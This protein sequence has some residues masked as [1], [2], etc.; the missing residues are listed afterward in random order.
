M[1]TA[2][3]GLLLSLLLSCRGEQELHSDCLEN[4]GACPAR[5]A[6]TDCII[7]SNE[8]H[9]NAYCTHHDRDP[10]LAVNMIGCNYEYDRSPA[11]KCGCVEAVC[12]TQ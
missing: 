12:Q 10:P 1:K 5:S 6:D 7:V 9:P 11:W 2:L 8:C 4:P 3:V